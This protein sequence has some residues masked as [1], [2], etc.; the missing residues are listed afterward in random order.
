MGPGTGIFGARTGYF[1]AL[2]VLQMVFEGTGVVASNI[3]PDSLSRPLPIDP[4]AVV[5]V[6]HLFTIVITAVLKSPLVYLSLLV[7]EAA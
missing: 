2:T 6:S 5:T 7:D 3:L 1:D 4:T